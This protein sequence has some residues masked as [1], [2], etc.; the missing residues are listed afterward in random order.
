MQELIETRMAD[1][2][3]RDEQMSTVSTT[4]QRDTGA[5]KPSFSPTVLQRF[6]LRWS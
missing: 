3:A 5:T 2:I 4:K 1:E 6:S